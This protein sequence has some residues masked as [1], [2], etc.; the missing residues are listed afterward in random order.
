M[1]TKYKVLLTIGRHEV[2]RDLGE[3]EIDD[4]SDSEYIWAIK[5]FLGLEEV[6]VSTRLSTQVLVWDSPPSVDNLLA[7]YDR[8]TGKIVSL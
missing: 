4:L 3:Y 6:K 2:G 5:Q 1:R 7:V 8:S